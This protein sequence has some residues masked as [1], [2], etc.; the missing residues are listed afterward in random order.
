[1]LQ[2][3]EALT[4]GAVAGDARGDEGGLSYRVGDYVRS[5]RIDPRCGFGT[6]VYVDDDGD[7]VVQPL[8]IGTKEVVVAKQDLSPAV[9]RAQWS[10]APRMEIRNIY[11]GNIAA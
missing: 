2:E 4:A 9:L 11:E 8:I 10:G 1:M 5:E 3:M 6:V 7:C